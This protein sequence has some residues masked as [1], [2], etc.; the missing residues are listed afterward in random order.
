MGITN[1]RLLRKAWNLIT[2]DI[3]D[4]TSE[5]IKDAR[6]AIKQVNKNHRKQKS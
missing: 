6:K 1:R 4:H 3:D 5:R 2:V